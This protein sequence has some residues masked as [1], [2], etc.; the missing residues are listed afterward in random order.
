MNSKATM[1]LVIHIHNHLHDMEEV[2]ETQRVSLGNSSTAR[3]AA[4]RR[5]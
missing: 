5:R 3:L 4:W 1:P 2:N